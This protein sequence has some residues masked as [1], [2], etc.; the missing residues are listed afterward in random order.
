MTDSVA[1]S[2]ITSFK[3]KFNKILKHRGDRGDEYSDL[4]KRQS[5]D[6]DISDFLNTSQSA[7]KIPSLQTSRQVASPRIDVSI[8]S[9]WAESGQLSAITPGA[10]SILTPISSTKKSSRRKG[11]SVRFVTSNV[12]I[13]GF[14]GDETQSPTMEISRRKATLL[15]S[16]SDR[17]IG[18]SAS[19]IDGTIP[20]SP[21]RPGMTER[22]QTSGGNDHAYSKL[23]SAGVFA[24]RPPSKNETYDDTIPISPVVEPSSPLPATLTHAVPS[25]LQIA[26]KNQSTS[27]TKTRSNDYAVSP[28]AAGSTGERELGFGQEQKSLDLPIVTRHQAHQSL[29]ETQH[30]MRLEEGRAFSNAYRLSQNYGS[31]DD[32][33]RPPSRDSDKFDS[34]KQLPLPPQSQPMYSTTLTDGQS[35]KEVY[36]TYTKGPSPVLSLPYE[37]ALSTPRP[38]PSSAASPNNRPRSTSSPEEARSRSGSLTVP[39]RPSSSRHSRHSSMDHDAAYGDAEGYNDSRSTTST[40]S[41]RLNESRRLSHEITPP[42]GLVPVRKAIPPTKQSADEII[43]QEKGQVISDSH[44][45]QLPLPPVDPLA[46]RAFED[47]SDRVMQTRGIFRL[48]NEKERSGIKTTMAE[49]LRCAQ[50]WLQVA[51]I[52]LQQIKD[53]KGLLNQ[54]HVDAAKAW[55]LITEGIDENMIKSANTSER[56]RLDAL[57]YHFQLICLYMGRKNLLPPQAALI[58]DQSMNLWIKYPI[59]VKDVPR[60]LRCTPDILEAD[61]MIPFDDNNSGY[62]VV[63]RMLSGVSASSEV[64]GVDQ[65]NMPC[66]LSV[67][68][69][70]DQYR[71]SI[72]LASQDDTVNVFVGSQLDPSHQ[73]PTWYHVNWKSKQSAIIISL[74]NK[75]SL[76][77][78]LKEDDWRTVSG[79]FEHTR[80]MEKTLEPAQNERILLH[81]KL[82]EC[83]YSTSNPESKNPR[84]YSFPQEKV[85]G[86]NIAVFKIVS[87]SSE[88]LKAYRIAIV[89]PTSSRN[90]FSLNWTF[91]K[92]SGIRYE[93]SNERTITLYQPDETH[94]GEI[95]LVFENRPGL[96]AF[97]DLVK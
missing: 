76:T 22:A 67:V 74:P 44:N 6:D 3:A 14:G 64:I 38:S 97:L 50:W 45:Q 92:K 15:R 58:Q 19:L 2:R 20:K 37:D 93:S 62:V 86:P 52:Q 17:N 13:I 21:I 54:A 61:D 1:Q 80:R 49:M 81:Q 59:F 9:R 10:D 85:I 40:I 28:V 56:Y 26:S 30:R 68:R 41:Q 35:N 75:F 60:T 27:L 78:T 94:R 53:S 24:Q 63:Q 5:V 18:E 7:L 23:L 34:E 57:R 39:Y 31:L 48:I 33:S 4:P 51:K 87:S 73:H 65:S 32:T 66:I 90:L 16:F 82:N 47:F 72:L 71:A 12:E 43:T 84:H 77:I 8:A 91:E 70:R 83:C 29:N 46:L 36:S 89:M 25:S 79:I 11:L 42:W 88:E 95:K 55:W 96:N 69:H